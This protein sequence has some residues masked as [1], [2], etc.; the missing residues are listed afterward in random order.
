MLLKYHYSPE[1]L[2]LNNGNT[3]FRLNYPASCA[4]FGDIKPSYKIQYNLRIFSSLHHGVCIT[5][6]LSPTEQMS[7]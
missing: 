2:Q 4:S 3:F 1:L 6:T 5:A 7:Q